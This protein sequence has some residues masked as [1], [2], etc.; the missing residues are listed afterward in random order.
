ML[1]R[2]EKI[3][4]LKDREIAEERAREQRAVSDE[5][6]SPKEPGWKPGQDPL[7]GPQ[8]A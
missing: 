8:Q 3:D 7:P 1:L 4:E 6:A 5:A 2:G